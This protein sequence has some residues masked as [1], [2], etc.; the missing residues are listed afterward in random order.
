MQDTDYGRL[1]SALKQKAEKR[2]NE[3]QMTKSVEEIREELRSKIPTCASCP[4]W[5]PTPSQG[6]EMGE[7]HKR[8]PEVPRKDPTTDYPFTVFIPIG[9][10]E[11]CGEHPKFLAYM[12]QFLRSTQDA[13]L[14]AL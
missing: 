2:L 4:F 8:A 13:P 1:N 6:E 14:K 9:E 7:C 3:I 11:W 5:K 10:W 12:D